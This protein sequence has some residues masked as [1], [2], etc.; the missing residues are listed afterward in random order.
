MRKNKSKKLRKS[1]KGLRGGIVGEENNNDNINNNINSVN[2]EMKDE[3][4]GREH[5]FDDDTLRQLLLEEGYRRVRDHPPYRTQEEYFNHM[6]ENFEDNEDLQNL[7]LL[8]R[9]NGINDLIQE[10]LRNREPRIPNEEKSH[11]N[12]EGYKSALDRLGRIENGRDYNE[13]V[14]AINE[15]NPE[16]LNRFVQ[17][18]DDSRFIDSLNNFATSYNRR[19]EMDYP[20]YRTRPSR[21]RVP[22]PENNP[23]QEQLDNMTDFDIEALALEI[24]WMADERR[25]EAE[26]KKVEDQRVEREERRDRRYERQTRRNR[27]ARMIP[28]E[29]EQTRINRD[30]DNRRTHV[31]R[32]LRWGWPSGNQNQ[33]DRILSMEIL[34][35]GFIRNNIPTAQVIDPSSRVPR[36]IRNLDS[37]GRSLYGGKINKKKRKSKSKR[38]HKS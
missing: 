33:Q 12:W 32:P 8:R 11:N 13:F 16:L 22:D 10:S 37:I 35:P 30:L 3:K 25:E 18:P 2:R 17:L 14:V 21:L 34:N 1:V 24:P 5:K 7:L 23:T 28:G 29:M 31:S 9:H 6:N 36:R 38:K 20:E 27:R 4:D 15:R 19:L 26:E